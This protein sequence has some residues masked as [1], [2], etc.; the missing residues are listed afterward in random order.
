MPSWADTGS[1][2]GASLDPEPLGPPSAPPLLPPWPPYAPPPNLTQVEVCELLLEESE[3]EQRQ[4]I[5]QAARESAEKW[6]LTTSAISITSMVIDIFL[7]FLIFR[8]YRHRWIQRAGFSFLVALLIGCVFGY[9]ASLIDGAPP[10][11]AL[12]RVRLAFIY[13][14]IY[15]LITP[16]FAK[17]TSL[18]I[19]TR[20]AM[21]AEHAIAWDRRARRISGSVYAVQLLTLTIFLCVT[22]GKPGRADRYQTV[23][24]DTVSEHAFHFMNGFIV[25]VLLFVIFAEC[26]YLQMSSFTS[27]K[28]GLKARAHAA[29]HAPP[30]ASPPPPPSPAPP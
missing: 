28:Q 1:G 17:V 12:C 2:D 14:F 6:A 30:P 11:A 7:I 20:N 19:T 9:I 5:L 18:S 23:C 8:L 10:S 3:E 21:L 29:S 16:L 15:G 4:L 22:A 25:V 26:A 27:V 24:T 13:L